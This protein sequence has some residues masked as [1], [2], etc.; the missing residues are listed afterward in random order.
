MT[1]ITYIVPF[2]PMT[3]A[4]TW[5]VVGFYVI[6]PDDAV[7]WF[8]EITQ[9]GCDYPGHS[10]SRWNSTMMRRDTTTGRVNA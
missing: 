3:F 6:R 8:G 7:A 9:V 2:V 5:G 4:V 10:R 1:N